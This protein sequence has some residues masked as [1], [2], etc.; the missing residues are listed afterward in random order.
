MQNRI[1]IFG[2]TGSGK[3]TFARN[4]SKKLKIPFY[5]TDD[6]VYKNLGKEKYTEKQKCEN[7]KKVAKKRKWI[8]E[9]VHAGEWIIPAFKR[10]DLVI[11]L[12]VMRFTMFKR[13]IK[14]YFLEKKEHYAS[15]RNLAQMLYWTQVYYTSKGNGKIHK[16]LINDYKKK[17]IKLKNKKEITKFLKSLD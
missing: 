15:L 5:T 7:L 14:R 10:S 4:L 16:N 13:V 3:T 2:G 1:F 11:V 8:I 6:M 9:G 12:D 17:F